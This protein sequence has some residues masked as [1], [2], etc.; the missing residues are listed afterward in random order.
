MEKRVVGSFNSDNEVLYAIEGLIRQGHRETDLMVVAESRSAIPLVTSRTGVMVEADQQVR[1]LTGVMMN[2]YLSMLS[3]GMGGTQANDLSSRL[4]E[5]GLTEYT[6]KQCE[7]ELNKGKIMLLVDT[8]T[9]YDSPIYNTEYETEN[10]GAVRLHEEQLDITKE[11]VQVGELQ[12]RK[13]TME[14]Q[15]TVH[16]PIL[17]EE[18]YVERRPVIDGEF[19]GSPFNEDEIIRIPITEERIEVTKRPIIVEEVIIGKRKIQETKQVQD[20]I[21]K[22]E[23]QIERS[24]PSEITAGKLVNQDTLGHVEDTES[25][26]ILIVE[27]NPDIE[28]IMAEVQKEEIRE[29]RTG[30]VAVQGEKNK[31]ESAVSKKDEVSGTLTDS[32]VSKKSKSSTLISADTVKKDSKSSTPISADTVKKDSKSSTPNSAAT[33]KKEAAIHNNEDP[34]IDE[35]NKNNKNQTKKKK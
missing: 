27:G 12:L 20:T 6:A 5:R 25:P 3:A 8:N 35:E 18:L 7:E 14:E 16:V 32:P 29:K 17:R 1:T 23:A 15:R 26:D 11:R 24:V 22:E 4:I 19:E 9:T 28:N 31:P 30:S 2:S 33:V 10:S 34:S 13:E 21:R